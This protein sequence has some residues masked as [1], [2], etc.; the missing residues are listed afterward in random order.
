VGQAEAATGPA[1]AETAVRAAAAMVVES[2]VLAQGRAKRRAPF[3]ASVRQ[4]RYY[5]RRAAGGQYQGE[6]K[7]ESKPVKFYV[8]RSFFV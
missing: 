7:K 4:S 5:Q 6:K 2:T 1:A 3:H 8:F